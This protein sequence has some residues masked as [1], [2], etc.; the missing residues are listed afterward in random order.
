MNKGRCTILTMINIIFLALIFY[1]VISGLQ[2]GFL[3]YFL[4][5]LLVIVC[6]FT[7][8]LYYR[9][10]HNFLYSLIILFLLP[11]ILAVIFRFLFHVSIIRTKYVKW[12]VLSQLNNIAG[13]IIG[14]IWGI[15]WVIIIASIINIIPFNHPSF[16][17]F[18]ENIS[19]SFILSFIKKI[20]PVRELFLVDNISNLAKIMNNQNAIK[21]L[22]NNSEFQ[23]LMKQEKIKNFIKD[24]TVMTQLKNKQ[25]LSLLDNP[26]FIAILE[27]LKLLRKFMRIDFG[28]MLE[29]RKNTGEN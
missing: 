14:F 7:S 25:I 9:E 15:F 3:S 20:V 24:R 16:I 5:F 21:N 12:R 27:D 23:E 22:K 28:S 10:T 29:Y 26:K 2:K 13:S 19:D 18:K 6:I 8:W 17:K 4:E 1:F 11:I